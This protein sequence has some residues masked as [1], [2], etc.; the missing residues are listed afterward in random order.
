MKAFLGDSAHVLLTT[1]KRNEQSTVCFIQFLWP[2]DNF[3]VGE[4]IYTDQADNLLV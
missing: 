1:K 2:D 3:F 4:N